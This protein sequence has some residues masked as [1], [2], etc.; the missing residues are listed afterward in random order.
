MEMRIEGMGV[1][2]ND[3]KKEDEEEDF[4]ELDQDSDDDDDDDDYRRSG[5]D[6][7]DE[8][9]AYCIYMELERYR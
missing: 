3:V 1:K 7:S 6:L 8:E 4:S 9:L 2:E 5:Y